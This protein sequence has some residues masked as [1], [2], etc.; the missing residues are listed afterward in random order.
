M[1]SFQNAKVNH[2]VKAALWGK[3]LREY[4][5]KKKT[6]KFI[7]QSSQKHKLRYFH[8]GNT[9][10]LK[11]RLSFPEKE[12]LRKYLSHCKDRMY[13]LN[14]DY[15]LMPSEGNIRSKNLL[16]H[17]YTNSY[18]NEYPQLTL[19]FVTC[20][21]KIRHF[22]KFFIATSGQLQAIPV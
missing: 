7:Y 12:Y 4:S 1:T 21:R 17:C 9:I 15:H 11:E 2:H 18:L 13:M 10:A 16:I 3:Y 20:K 19:T 14:K 8:P 6:E 22:S 5:L